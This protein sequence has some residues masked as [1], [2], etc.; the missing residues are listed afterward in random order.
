MFAEV[1][2]ALRALLRKAA[3]NPAFHA[4][5]PD[6]RTPEYRAVLVFIMATP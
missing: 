2:N 3:E 6:A 4:R 1:A 5:R